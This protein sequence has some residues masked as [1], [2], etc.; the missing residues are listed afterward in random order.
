MERE[1]Q[2]L[3]VGFE[4]TVRYMDKGEVVISELYLTV[5]YGTVPRTTLYSYVLDT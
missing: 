3:C 5:P 4:A 1:E 2:F